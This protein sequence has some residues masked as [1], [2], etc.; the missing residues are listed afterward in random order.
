MNR[1]YTPPTTKI[2]CD[3]GDELICSSLSPALPDTVPVIHYSD[4]MI[5]QFTGINPRTD[6]LFLDNEPMWVDGEPPTAKTA[7]TA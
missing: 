5:F 3:A 2:H 7:R 6:E 4:G 1:N